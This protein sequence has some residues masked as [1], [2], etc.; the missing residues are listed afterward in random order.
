MTVYA[1]D[2]TIDGVLVTADGE[3]LDPR[4]DAQRYDADF[5]WSYEGSAPRQL[6]FALLAHHLHDPARAA[7]LSER[8]MRDVTANFQNDWDMTTS[9]I[10]RVLAAYDSAETR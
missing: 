5:E 8:F 7:A 6:A 9:D 2:R 3:P 10:E 4:L 1:G